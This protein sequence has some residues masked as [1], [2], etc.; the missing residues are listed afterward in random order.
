MAETLFQHDRIARGKPIGTAVRGALIASFSVD[1]TPNPDASATAQALLR[2]LRD[3]EAW[4][5]CDCAAG[6]SLMSPRQ[7]PSGALTLVRHGRTPHDPLCPFFRLRPA[8]EISPAAPSLPSM[9]P[10]QV[11]AASLLEAMRAILSRAGYDRVSGSDLRLLGQNVTASDP[12]RHYGQIDVAGDILLN[13]TSLRDQWVTHVGGLKAAQRSGDRD[14]TVFVG[15]VNE[16]G[17]ALVR[18]QRDGTSYRFAAA[19]IGSRAPIEGPFWVIGCLDHDR[20]AVV[21]GLAWPVISGGVLLPVESER[22]REIARV[23][24]RQLVYWRERHGLEVTL[25]VPLSPDDHAPDFWL[26]VGEHALAVDLVPLPGHGRS[27]EEILARSHGRAGAESVLVDT[28]T[29]D[30]WRRMLTSRVL[31]WKAGDSNSLDQT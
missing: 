5:D 19:E 13:D 1:G 17:D 28:E 27:R 15:V 22:H 9:V 11:G 14:R 12:G 20:Q 7:L 26:H 31:R 6:G 4:L 18:T 8:A 30:V 10:G 23:L 16:F 21:P 29:P 3:T 25:Q 2:F 24:C